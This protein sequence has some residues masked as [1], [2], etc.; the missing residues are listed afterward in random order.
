MENSVDDAEAFDKANELIA[1]MNKQR[2]EK[3]EAH[4]KW[5]LNVHLKVQKSL[6]KFAEMNEMQEKEKEEKR[7]VIE[8]RI[9]DRKKKLLLR[10][11][12]NKKADHLISELQNYRI[13]L[14]SI[15]FNNPEEG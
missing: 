15:N 6:K 9:E 4:R 2:R 5:T 8:Q 12:Y 13:S 1:R 7:H 11:E 3:T 10:K 14:P